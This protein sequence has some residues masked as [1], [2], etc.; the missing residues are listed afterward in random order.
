MLKAA[1]EE[2]S[3]KN[4]REE[5]CRS[6]VTIQLDEDYHFI[7]S[8]VKVSKLGFVCISGSLSGF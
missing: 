4:E 8:T 7:H 3:S 1:E 6:S 2:N 5:T